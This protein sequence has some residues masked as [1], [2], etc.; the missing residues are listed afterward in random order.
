MLVELNRDDIKHI[1][2]ALA[3]M[4]IRHHDMVEMGTLVTHG[5][6]DHFIEAAQGA[7]EFQE[8]LRVTLA[9]L[10]AE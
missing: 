10:P 3:Y 6:V 5:D 2:T 7:A 1:P 9:K 8:K 4:L